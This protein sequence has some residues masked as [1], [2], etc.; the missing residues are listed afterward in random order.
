MRSSL[1]LGIW[2]FVIIIDF[3]LFIGSTLIVCKEGRGMT[4][5]F[6]GMGTWMETGLGT[7]MGIGRMGAIRLIVGFVGFMGKRFIIAILCETSG[8]GMLLVTMRMGIE[9]PRTTL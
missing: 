5:G 7:G 6:G 9:R 3:I 1:F 2:S 4:M 8:R